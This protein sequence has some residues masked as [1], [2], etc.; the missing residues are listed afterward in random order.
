MKA[1]FDGPRVLARDVYPG[2]GACVTVELGTLL[3]RL[4]MEY[5][6]D[7]VVEIATR[8]EPPEWHHLPEV[9]LLVNGRPYRAEEVRVGK[10]FED[11][12]ALCESL[13]TQLCQVEALFREATVPDTKNRLAAIRQQVVQPL[14]DLVESNR[15]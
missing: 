8:S 13:A 7:F 6:T 4:T 3:V 5:G 15:R 2:M 12:S 10:S 11:M 9:L 14:V 1:K